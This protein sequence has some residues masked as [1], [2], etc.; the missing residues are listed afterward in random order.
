LRR[1]LPRRSYRRRLNY[2][3]KPKP[4][5][6]RGLFVIRMIKETVEDLEYKGMK[7]IQRED[8]FRFGTDAVLLASFVRAKTSESV[9]DFGSG[10]GILTVLVSARTG[11]AVTA[12]ELDKT[13]A[14]LCARNIE[15]N[16]LS[17]AK[18]VNID[19]R[20]A[21]KHIGRVNAVMMNPPYDD[22]LSGEVSENSLKKNARHELTITLGEAVKSAAKVLGTGGRLYMIH[23]ASRLADIFRA[24]S[25]AKLEPKEIRFIAPKEGAEPGHVLIYAKKDAKSGLKVL[26]TLNVLDRNGNETAELRR[27][28]HKETQE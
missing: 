10:S 25:A 3:V 12:V 14:E 26:D 2:K 1:H 18:V 9:A 16:G 13:A 17:K 28:Y 7:L 5:H 22:P 11:A 15:L 23:R 8:G 27:I 4:A 6:K 20:D 24:L 19:M 21:A